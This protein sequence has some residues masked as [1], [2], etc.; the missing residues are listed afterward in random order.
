MAEFHLQLR[1]LPALLAAH[2]RI[3]QFFDFTFDIL[4][5]IGIFV[6]E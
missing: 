4:S 6:V 3:H 5:F 2:S 1:Y